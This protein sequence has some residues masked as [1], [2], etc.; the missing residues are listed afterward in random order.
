MG[1]RSLEELVELDVTYTVIPEELDLEEAK[2][3]VLNACIEA[4]AQKETPWY[5]AAYLIASTMKES[6]GADWETSC[7][8]PAEVFQDSIKGE[9]SKEAFLHAIRWDWPDIPRT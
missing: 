4:T 5:E 1:C 9:F 7:A 8:L 2:I 3:F 6:L